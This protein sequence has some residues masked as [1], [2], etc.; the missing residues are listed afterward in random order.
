[1]K[2]RNF[3]KSLGI[4]PMLSIVPLNHKEK[5]YSAEYMNKLLAHKDYNLLRFDIGRSKKNDKYV[6][7][8][9]DKIEFVYKDRCILKFVLKE[10]APSYYKL[11]KFYP[12][13]N[14]IAWQQRLTD[15]AHIINLAQRHRKNQKY[16]GL[17]DFTHEA[18]SWK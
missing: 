15:K 5:L 9:V 13:K 1:M 16:P 11:E 7:L 8:I 3:F 14:G 4:V 12:D 2:R 6:E 17:Y 10:N 18:I